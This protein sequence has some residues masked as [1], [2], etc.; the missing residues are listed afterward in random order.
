[1]TAYLD[2]VFCQDS[3]DLSIVPDGAVDAAITSLPWGNQVSYGKDPEN[4]GNY[5]GDEFVTR[6][7]KHLQAVMPKIK[8]SGNLMIELQSPIRDGRC[9]L[10]EEKFVIAAVE[11]CGLHLIQKVYSIRTNADPLAPANRLRRGVVPTFHFVLDP[12]KYRVYKDAVR[13]P[14][15]WAARD[16]RPKKYHPAGKDPGDLYWTKD[17]ILK[18]R[19]PDHALLNHG[20]DDLNYVAV[21]KTQDQ[22][23]LG[24]PGTMSTALAE[25]LVLWTTAPGDTVLDIMCGVGTTLLAAKKHGRQFVGFEINPSYAAVA[26]QRLG[27]RSGEEDTVM[28]KWMNAK[29]AADYVG[30]E[31]ST[32]YSKTSRREMPVHKGTGKPRYHQ[33]ELDAWVRGEWKPEA[34]QSEQ[35]GANSA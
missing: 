30:L 27:L 32:I 15:A 11:Q 13:K 19:A 10:I 29:Q 20:R 34:I 24:H 17:E 6:G 3:K 7:M 2:R 25:F 22:Q 14:S 9:S 12:E 1:M 18:G 8:P 26:R 31:L 16:K 5:D 4:L 28:S 33:D 23:E 35:T 21:S